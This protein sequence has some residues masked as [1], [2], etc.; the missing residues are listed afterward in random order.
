M[1][2]FEVGYTLGNL[3]VTKNYKQDGHNMTE[4]VCSCGN[5][6]FMRSAEFSRRNKLGIASC[7]KCHDKRMVTNSPAQKH[8]QCGTKEYRAWIHLRQR[9]NNPKAKQYCDYG[10]RGISVCKEWDSFD[11]FLEDMGRCPGNNLSIDRIDVDGNYCKENCRWATIIEQNNNQRRNKYYTFNGFT[12]TIPQ[13]LRKFSLS[14][15]D[16]AA[17]NR[18]E[19]GW[20]IDYVFSKP[21]GFIFVEEKS[22]KKIYTVNGISGILSKL[23]RHFKTGISLQSALARIRKGESIENVVLIKKVE[24]HL[25]K[26]KGIRYT[27]RG[28]TNTIPGFIRDFNLNITKTSVYYRIKIGWDIERAIFEPKETRYV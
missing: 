18:I 2:L 9:C 3:T 26:T 14:I 24:Y 13:I 27:V 12:G 10:G 4:C 22:N 20:P 21:I 5:V 8:K 15:S 11:K 25:K 17:R 7:R 19:R 16:E 1:A 23:L 6:I 28:V